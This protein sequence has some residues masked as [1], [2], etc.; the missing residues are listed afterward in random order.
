MYKTKTFE[1]DKNSQKHLKRKNVY[2]SYQ[3][4]P[5]EHLVVVLNMDLLIN[6][7]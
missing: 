1:Y 3:G 5:T 2:T 6:P 4:P 7:S